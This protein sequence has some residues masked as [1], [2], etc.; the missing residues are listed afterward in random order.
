MGLQTTE[1]IPQGHHVCFYSGVLVPSE[2]IEKDAS[3]Y[4]IYYNQKFSIDGKHIGNCLGRYINHGHDSES[5]CEV[6]HESTLF[7]I[8]HRRRYAVR[9]IA[10]KDIKAY[11]EL[12]MDY[13]ST[14]WQFDKKLFYTIHRKNRQ[15][16]DRH[17]H[18]ELVTFEGQRTAVYANGNSTIRWDSASSNSFS[19]LRKFPF[20]DQFSISEYNVLHQ[21]RESAIKNAYP[22]S[23]IKMYPLS[24]DNE[25]QISETKSLMLCPVRRDGYCAYV[26]IFKL[27]QQKNQ[28]FVDFYEELGRD[29]QTAPFDL[30]T[31][32]DFFTIHDKVKKMLAHKKKFRA[33]LPKSIWG[34]FDFLNDCSKKY[35]KKIF[36]Y[37]KS[38]KFFSCINGNEFLPLQIIRPKEFD[39]SIFICYENFHYEY[40]IKKII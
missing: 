5:N 11:D 13:G 10:K 15:V 29:L 30:S 35:N 17:D 22:I 23:I 34:N 26:S 6:L 24:K 14:Y 38:T 1:A 9:V 20:Y 40:F 32:L 31:P 16:H 27:L 3:D 39:S 36:V 25:I 7:K 8:K 4:C 33:P 28:T 21:T 2:K 19:Y 18:N 37:Y 12:L